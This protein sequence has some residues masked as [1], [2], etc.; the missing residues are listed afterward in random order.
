[1]S[2][3][4]GGLQPHNTPYAAALRAFFGL[5]GDEDVLRE[6]VSLA[7]HMLQ[8][9]TSHGGSAK[10][11]AGLKAMY[12]WMGSKCGMPDF[13]AS[14]GGVDRA[15]M[16]LGALQPAAPLTNAFCRHAGQELHAGV[17]R[18]AGRVSPLVPR[19]GRGPVPG[20]GPL[21]GGLVQLVALLPLPPW[22]CRRR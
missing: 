19:A 14:A 1:M 11:Q 15:C 12:R 21:P 17:C 18:G 20:A 4:G 3:A 16:Q 2:Y 10:V 6:A 5:Y 7:Q 9:T 8:A 22:L 13:Q